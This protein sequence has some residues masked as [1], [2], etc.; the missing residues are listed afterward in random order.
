M[1]LWDLFS[2][3]PAFTP[4]PMLF[5]SA[6]YFLPRLSAQVSLG[7]CTERC[8]PRISPSKSFESILVHRPL[9]FW[10][11]PGMPGSNFSQAFQASTRDGTFRLYRLAPGNWYVF[12][13]LVRFFLDEIF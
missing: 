10:D 11:I 13:D 2:S 9:S 6:L 3:G 12:L 5:Q 1:G 4:L 8:V 7:D